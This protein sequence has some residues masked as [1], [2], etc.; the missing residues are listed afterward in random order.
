MGGEGVAEGVRAHLAV[1][2]GIVGVALD[3]LVEPLAGQSAAAE[4]DEQLALEPAADELLTAGSQVALDR[5]PRLAAERDDPLLRALS[6]GADEPAGH[7][8]V[9][10][11]E[12]DRLRRPQTAAVHD[13]QQGAVA[14]A[15]RV[16]P[17]GAIE[18]LAD[19]A[20]AENVGKLS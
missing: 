6:V 14:Q 8:D 13:L 16:G 17:V 2:A 15:D 12:S 1:E 11:L 19:L 3:D 4:V 18:Q 10:D 7:V 5:A 20:L 9:A